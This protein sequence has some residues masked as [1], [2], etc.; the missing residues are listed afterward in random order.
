[1]KIT[2]TVNTSN[3]HKS[4][5]M[6]Q[7]VKISS[8]EKVTHD[9]IKIV[10]DKPDHYIFSPGQ[11]TEVTINKPG[12]QKEKRPFTFTCLPTDDYLEFTIKTYPEH[13]G[14]TNELLKLKKNDELILH[15]VFGAILYEKEGVFIAGGAGITPFI[16][17]FRHLQRQNKIGNNLLVFANK[18]KADI[19][20]EKEFK[21]MLGDAF[22]NILSNEKVNGYHHGMITEEFLKTNIKNVHQEFYV[23]GPPPMM[24]A[25]LKQLASLRVDKNLITKEAV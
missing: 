14:V 12:W 3:A 4:H 5:T 23:C 20:L 18:T 22:I 15:D 24:D 9:V 21:K 19:I 13:K 25:V 6:N 16:A 7:I 8:T 2:S 17:I 11:A 1:M 10:T